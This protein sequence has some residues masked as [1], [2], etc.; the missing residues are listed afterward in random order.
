[1]LVVVVGALIGPTAW[2]QQPLK[3]AGQDAKPWVLHDQNELSGVA[4]D[5]TRA[6]S[7]QIGVPIDYETMI[8]GSALLELYRRTVVSK[9][10]CCTGRASAIVDGRSGGRRVSPLYSANCDLDY[11]FHGD[12]GLLSGMSPRKCRQLAS[13]LRQYADDHR[14]YWTRA[15]D[16]ADRLEALAEEME[17]RGLGEDEDPDPTQ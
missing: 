7:K 17:R 2:G 13:E 16:A 4:V 11:S 8:F 14:A 15:R 10:G 3:A 6:I 12:T 5:L 1:M 9:G